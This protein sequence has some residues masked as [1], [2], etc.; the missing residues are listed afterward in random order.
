MQHN[1]K[2]RPLATDGAQIVDLLGSNIDNLNSQT[3]KR[4]QQSWRDVLPVHPAAEL[5][6]MMSRDELLALGKDIK[7]NGL[8]VP[9]I[10][11]SPNNGRDHYLLD[12][13]NRL[14]AMELV[15]LPTVYPNG[16]FRGFSGDLN[17]Q[18]VTKDPYAYVLSANIHRRHLTAEQRR[19]LIAKVIAANPGKSDRQIAKQVR[20]DHKTVGKVRA[21]GEDVG[22][23]PHVDIRTDT[24]GRKQPAKR[25]AADRVEARCAAQWKAFTAQDEKPEYQQLIED[26]VSCAEMAMSV[27]NLDFS[28]GELPTAKMRKIAQEVIDTWAEILAALSPT[29][30]AEEPDYS[31]PADGS[32]PGFLDRRG[33]AT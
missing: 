10:L 17:S 27:K 3:H 31:L 4:A 19:E 8:K 1:A 28:V 11:W 32:V 25:T 20:A 15:E 7:K 29:E 13:R 14:D 21:K 16:L 18:S 9:V 24:K 23:I 26:F 2:R 33:G 12:G 22:T 5:F 6:P 30:A